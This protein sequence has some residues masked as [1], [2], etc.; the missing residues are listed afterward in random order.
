MA[1]ETANRVIEAPQEAGDP[2]TWRAARALRIVRP[3]R[4]A[5]V[6]PLRTDREYQVGRAETVDLYFEDE[7]VSRYH[8]FL[9]FARERGVWAYRDGGSTFGS[10][11]SGEG[12]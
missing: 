10:T 12:K 3:G 4:K 1:Q 7:S 6:I 2:S 9:Y 11:L 5:Y 8:G